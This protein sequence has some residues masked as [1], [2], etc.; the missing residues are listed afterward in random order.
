MGSKGPDG[1]DGINGRPGKNGN[2]GAQGLPGP[3]GLPGAMGQVGSP[4]A[5]GVPGLQGRRGPQGEKGKAGVNGKDGAD[6]PKGPKGPKGPQGE[7]GADGAKGPAGPPGARG[8]RGPQGPAGDKGEDGVPGAAGEV[9]FPGP[10][11][12]DGNPGERGRRGQKGDTGFMGYKGKAGPQGPKGTRGL[13]G[14]S[15]PPGDKGPKGVQ[16]PTGLPGPT[17]AAGPMGLPGKKGPSGDQGPKGF[18][19]ANGQQGDPGDAGPPGLPGPSTIP[20]WMGGGLP[21]GATKGG[22]EGEEEALP[23][24]GPSPPEERIPETNPFLNIY[25]FYSSE[26]VEDEEQVKTKLN[27]IQ[28]KV[29]KFVAK[30]DGL[31]KMTAARTCNDL[32]AYNPE[33]KS[34][35]YF[36]D[37]NRGCAEDAI[38][39]QCNFNEEEDKIETCVHPA[40][41]ATIQNA[42]WESKVLS[43]SSDKY[44]VEH[45]GLGSVDYTAEMTQMKYLGL[46]SNKAVQNITINCK[47]RPVWYNEQTRGWESA[48]KFKGMKDSVFEKTK[49]D[50]KFTPKVI[51][52]ECAFATKSWRSTVLQFTS[53]KYIRLPIVDFAPSKISNRNAEYGLEMGPVCFY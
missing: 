33:L 6:G 46:L 18:P 36:I 42:H 1:S 26:K 28:T 31:T 44:F 17:G 51:K 40:Q 30:P 8:D 35:M 37:P 13:P 7:A 11:G 9:G 22:D 39:V 50:N 20:P 45:H 32:K 16:G 24:E 49:V 25:K 15:G 10:Q 47:E 14:Y 2:R 53:N 3:R 52:D 5:P 38:K 43:A 27:A 34:G 19:G 12:P 23:E 48:M 29:N 4:G 41:T 21:D